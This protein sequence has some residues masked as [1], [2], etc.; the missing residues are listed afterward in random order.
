MQKAKDRGMYF[1]SKVRSRFLV[2][3]SGV[4]ID[5]K[6]RHAGLISLAKTLCNTF[7]WYWVH[8]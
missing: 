6:Y 2:S 3:F 7:S 4:L 8:E 1:F 5:S